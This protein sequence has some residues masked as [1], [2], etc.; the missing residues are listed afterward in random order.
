MYS[1]DRKIGIISNGD[2]MLKYL[3]R[4]F[5]DIERKVL[6][7][8]QEKLP[9]HLTYHNYCHTID[10]VNQT[11]L[12]RIGEGVSDEHFFLLKTAALFHDA[13]HTIQSPNHYHYSTIIAK[14]WFLNYSY[15]KEQ[16]DVIFETIMATQLPPEPKN[17]FVI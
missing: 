8:S 10:V 4:Q 7:F 1:E 2:F 11:E 9:E 13:G 3:L 17:L 15:S 5:N 16:I 6:D 14:E 12:I